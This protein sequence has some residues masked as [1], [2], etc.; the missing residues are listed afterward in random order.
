M[1][2]CCC[3]LRKKKKK[4]RSSKNNA[5]QVVVN[6]AIL[7][8]EEVVAEEPILKKKE[9]LGVGR[10]VEL[11]GLEKRPDLNGRVGRVIDV[12]AE[13]FE[14]ELSEDGRTRVVAVKP[15]NVAIAAVIPDAALRHVEAG[16][17]EMASPRGGAAAIA[18]F[19]IEL[20]ASSRIPLVENACG[21][22]LAIL[23]EITTLREKGGDVVAAGQR[24]EATLEIMK[25]IEE[26]AAP[27]ARDGAARLVESKMRELVAKLEAVED[28]LKVYGER[29]WLRKR[30]FLFARGS[31]FS[32]LDKD[33]AL[34]CDEVMRAYELARDRHV[35]RL[36]EAQTYK[37]EDAMREEIRKLVE[38]TGATARDA[39]SDLSYHAE[40]SQRVAAK[41][42][43]SANELAAELK[44]I[45]ENA[46]RDGFSQ[47]S[48]E[49]G[50]IRAD[51]LRVEQKIS[52][53][54]GDLLERQNKIRRR[55]DQYR[56]LERY[57]I[58]VDRME[59]SPFAAGGSARVHRGIF[60][61][62]DVAVK[63]IPLGGLTAARR[64]TMLSDFR[65]EVAIMVRLRSPLVVGFYGVVTTDVHY[66]D[67]VLQYVAGGSLRVK[68]D[69]GAP[70]ESRQRIWTRQIARGMQ[71]IY[72]HGI[73]HRD[74]KSSNVLLTLNGNAK[75][76]DFGLSR[77]EELRTHA[78]TRFKDGAP[79]TAPYMAP[80]LLDRYVFTEK[81]DVYSFAIVL[82]E[83]L[84]RQYPLAGL[85]MPQ[86]INKVVEK[87]K[88]PNV[89]SNL[90]AP[91][92]LLDLM[93][94][95]WDH[96]PN[97]RPTFADIVSLIKQEQPSL[98]FS[99]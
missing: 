65:R 62:H 14:V 10:E 27:L 87:K 38:S 99:D 92:D 61:D 7:E 35:S 45:V 89:P 41:D 51:V 86:I 60:E 49:V 20:G 93:Y 56:M 4:K 24:V 63:R 98:S 80:E 70:S 13:R 81:C 96:D 15:E 30:W 26:N 5:V 40:T 95:S 79:G 66:L 48:A 46:V 68:L 11:V 6:Q 75:I 50:E 17:E 32:S 76:A 73:E 36:L 47:V 88:R 28:I 54:R 55:D 37:L 64:E 2:S 19:F 3:K 8:E 29:G 82:Y 39:A 84:T 34:L 85:S 22:S 1:G 9:A 52:D 31:T 74:L 16:A 21:V 57:E 18:R 44:E 90:P 42:G 53:M 94:R 78:T 25:I 97:L 12:G 83:I 77:S 69:E 71:Y 59:E 91:P 67:L 72:S 23:N 58:Q 43:V 33:I